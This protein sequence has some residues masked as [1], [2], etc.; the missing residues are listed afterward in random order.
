MRGVGGVPIG[1]AA[2]Q[3][4]VEQ[5]V[6]RFQSG[7]GRCLVIPPEGT[8]GRAPTGRRASIASRVAAGVPIVLGYLDY[9][10]QV[11]GLGPAFMP[12]GDVA[13]DFEVFP[14]FY[15]KVQPRFPEKMN[16]RSIVPP[17][18]LEKG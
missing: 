5:A 17:P 18:E 9:G 12:T 1:R 14:R 6:A 11:A 16:L 3:G 7:G 10:R 4:T 15:E 2:L 8:R 13:A